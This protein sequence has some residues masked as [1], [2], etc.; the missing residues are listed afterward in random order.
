MVNGDMAMVCMEEISL[1]DDES[2]CTTSVS[3]IMKYDDKFNAPIYPSIWTTLHHR[4]LVIL[5]QAA[6]L[7]Y[8]HWRWYHFLSE[9]STWFLSFP[10]II[11]ETLIVVFGSFITYFMVWNQ[12][13]RPKLRLNDLKLQWKDL[14]TVD[15][16]IPCYNEPVEVREAFPMCVY[17]CMSLECHHDTDDIPLSLLP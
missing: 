4:L 8:V 3:D 16:M 5:A 2:S 13:E 17:V 6:Q 7:I 12:V 10:F 9:E 15:V 1:K 14:P 11:S